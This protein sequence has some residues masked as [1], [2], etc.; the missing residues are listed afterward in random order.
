MNVTVINTRS[1]FLDTF[2]TAG[3]VH[4]EFLRLYAN[5]NQLFESNLLS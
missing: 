1:F 2:W 3:F 4:S 5:E